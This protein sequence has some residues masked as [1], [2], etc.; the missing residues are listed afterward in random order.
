MDRGKKRVN[1]RIKI[2]VADGG[3]DFELDAVI[4]KLAGRNVVGPA[5]TVTDGPGLQAGR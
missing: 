1:Y 5:K 4:F 2:L 3:Q